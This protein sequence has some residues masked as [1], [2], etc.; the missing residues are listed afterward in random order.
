MT[1][2][3]TACL[4]RERPVLVLHVGSGGGFEA[5]GVRIGDLAA[6]TSEIVIDMGIENPDGRIPLR[7]LPFP[8]TGISAR[9]GPARIPLDRSFTEAAMNR[10]RAVYE[11]AGVR[12]LSGVFVTGSMVTATDRRADE[13]FQAYQPVMESMEGAAAAFVSAWY[14]I[15]MVEIRCASNR[16]GDR[17]RSDWNLSLACRRAGEA[18]VAV[19]S[20]V[21]A[22]VQ[23]PGSGT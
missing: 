10:L 4:E 22:L 6:A 17:K 13:L 16:V 20:H 15:P 14:G 8:V 19:L 9:R 23:E 5:G 21:A 3:M 11:P 2:A 12:T 18:A 1:Q 7:P